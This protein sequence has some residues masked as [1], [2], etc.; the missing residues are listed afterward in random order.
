MQRAAANKRE[1]LSAQG[2]GHKFRIFFSTLEAR[3]VPVGGI[4][5]D[6]R[7][8]FFDSGWID[9]G[10]LPAGLA[11]REGGQNRRQE[12]EPKQ[13]RHLAP[14][15]HCPERNIS[16]ENAIIVP[17]HENDI[18]FPVHGIGNLSA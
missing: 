17:S 4:S 6:E 5:D 10:R 7:D 14:Q 18:R 9:V 8:T 13:A 15:N 12:N 1:A 2:I 3:E 11:S 16:F